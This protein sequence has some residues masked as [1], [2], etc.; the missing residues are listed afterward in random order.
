M[1]EVGREGKV[2]RCE[3]DLDIAV[4][5]DCSE[6]WRNGAETQGPVSYL[7]NGRK[8]GGVTSWKGN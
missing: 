1:E 2:F 7:K 5:E 8:T 3:S 4:W 6:V